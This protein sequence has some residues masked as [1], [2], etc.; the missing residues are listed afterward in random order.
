M[1]QIRIRMLV[2][3]GHG[4]RLLDYLMFYYRCPEGVLMFDWA[5]APKWAQWVAMDESG[6]WYWYECK[7]TLGSWGEWDHPT[8]TRFKAVKLDDVD[9]ENSLEARRG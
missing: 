4:S 9:Y 5:N 2:Y 1:A 6:N 8:G 3:F 7:P